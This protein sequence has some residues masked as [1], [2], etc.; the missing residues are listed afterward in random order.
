[1]KDYSNLT[2]RIYTQLSPEL[3]Q[4]FHNMLT[5]MAKEIS[6]LYEIE[7]AKPSEAL[8]SLESIKSILYWYYDCNSINENCRKQKE[9]NTIKQT[10]IRLNDLDE[11]LTFKGGCFMSGF[12]NKDGKQVVA[13]P[14]SEYSRLMEQE[15][16]LSIIKEKKVDI[17]SFY[18]TFIEDDYDYNFYEKRY[19]TYGKYELTEEEFELLKRWLDGINN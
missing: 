14:L 16:V 6:R 17:E 3:S 13:M 18:T 19:G 15:Q 10:L 4:E 5:D 8:E 9:F 2:S 11:K 1:M 7:N 12:D